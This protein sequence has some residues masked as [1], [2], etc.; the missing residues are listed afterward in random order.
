MDPEN[1]PTKRDATRLSGSTL[2]C[3]DT[4]LLQINVLLIF[5]VLGVTFAIIGIIAGKNPNQIPAAKLLTVIDGCLILFLVCE[6][7]MRERSR[8][9]MDILARFYI[10]H[11]FWL[12][13]IVAWC[14]LVTGT[15][16]GTA[17]Y[18]EML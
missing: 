8:I 15:A 1:P 11:R 9:W 16:I 6:P 4:I 18:L 13:R 7:S 12:N 17:W 2:A 5:G 14:A 3:I 10:A